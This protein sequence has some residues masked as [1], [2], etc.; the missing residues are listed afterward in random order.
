MIT[1]S[2]DSRRKREEC[3]IQRNATSAMVNPWAVATVRTSSRA[4]KKTGFQYLYRSNTGGHSATAKYVGKLQYAIKDGNWKSE[5][6]AM[7]MEYPKPER[8][9]TWHGTSMRGV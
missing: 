2:P 3:A 5:R 8:K 7:R 4:S 1:A 6:T 9:H